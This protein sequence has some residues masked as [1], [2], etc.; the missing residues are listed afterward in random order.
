VP[1]VADL[2]HDSRLSRPGVAFAAVPGSRRDGHDFLD[3]A[4]RAGAEALVV[5]AD[6]EAEWAPF[7]TLAPLVVVDDVRAALGPL[8]SAVHGEPSSKLRIVGVTGTDGKT[9]SAHLIAHVLNACGLACG[10]LSSVGFNTGEGFQPNESHM[11]TLEATVVQSLLAEAVEAGR[12]SM[13]VEASSE[14]LAQHRLDGTQVDVA[15]FTNLS[16]DH[17]DFHETMER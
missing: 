8:A 6:H 17:L 9:T 11:T 3:A 14:G 12:A 15:V 5:Q 16:R 13:V 7:A 1:D 4:L 10:Y 2:T